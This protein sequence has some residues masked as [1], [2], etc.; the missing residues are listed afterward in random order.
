MDVTPLAA[1][2]EEEE[3]EQEGEVARV[4]LVC[5]MAAPVHQRTVEAVGAAYERLVRQIMGIAEVQEQED[6]SA[7]RTHGAGPSRAGAGVC[8]CG[9]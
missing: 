3:E 4:I 7:A 5:H 9:C 6:T 1:S 2:Q 8:L